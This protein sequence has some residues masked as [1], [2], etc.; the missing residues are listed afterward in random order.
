MLVR[1]LQY[2]REGRFH[3]TNDIRILSFIAFSY[4]NM[5]DTMLPMLSEASKGKILSPRMRKFILEAVHQAVA[6]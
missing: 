6:S 2:I 3:I 5:L 1:K 4:P